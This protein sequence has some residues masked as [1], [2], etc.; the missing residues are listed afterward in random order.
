MKKSMA[1]LIVLSLFTLVFT[2]CKKDNENQNN[3]T[4][5]ENTSIEQQ[6]TK[7]ETKEDTK[8]EIIEYDWKEE[9]TELSKLLPDKEGYLWRYNGFAEY[10]HEMILNTIYIEEDSIKYAI[11][12]KVDDVSGGESNA[13]YNINIEYVI[14]QGR[15]IQNKQEEIM[16]DS[17]FDSLVLVVSPL[18]VGNKWTQ[19]VKDKNGNDAEITAEITDVLDDGFGTYRIRYQQKDSDYYEERDIRPGIGVVAL[20]KLYMSD[21]GN[22]EIGY[23]IY[24]EASGYI[25]EGE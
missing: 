14:E 23:Q 4:V 11:T 8:E 20:K 24:P 25:S 12:G 19:K 17:E 13:D 6:E 1:L 22:F 18:K 15:L 10:G 5:E 7:E 16:M 21:E 2:G 9:N 3:Q